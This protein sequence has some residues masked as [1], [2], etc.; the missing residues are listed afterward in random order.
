MIVN[1]KLLLL[2]FFSILDS[3]LLLWLVPIKELGI[4]DWLCGLVLL[5]GLID[6]CKESTRTGVIILISLGVIL[7]FGLL[8]K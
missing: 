2:V 6:L 7:G 3:I 4:K 5:A 1:R 8:I